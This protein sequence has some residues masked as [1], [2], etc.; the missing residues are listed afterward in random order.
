VEQ[1]TFRKVDFVDTTDGHVCIRSPLTHELAETMPQW[2]KSLGPIAEHVAHVFGK[3][4][5]GTY[6]AATPLTS[7][8]HR[9]AQAVVKA[10]KIEATR[11]ASGG[12]V[13][14]RP[15]VQP[16]AL[17]LWT[18]P[19]C[20]GAVTNPRHVRCEA[21]IVADPAQAPEI[22]GRRGA[23]I[24]A[25]KRALSEWD[26]ANPGTVYD[27]E[28]F[29]REILPGLRT[30]KPSEIAAAAGCS[31]ASASDIRRGKWTP[32]VS[33]W[34]TLAGLASVAVE[35]AAQGADTRTVEL[36]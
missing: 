9:D 25:R 11:R 3:A 21:C 18:C 30:V 8:R 14:Q 6:S 13:L 7:R 1:R 12:R 35:S 20:G 2:A 10:R 4:M 27:P 5:D 16:A 15:A 29:R 17:A 28:L 33:T 34:V 32:H 26:K 23:A 24:A 19:D 22:R 36:A 31:K